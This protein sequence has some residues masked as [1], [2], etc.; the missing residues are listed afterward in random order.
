MFMFGS[1]ASVWIA[2]SL[3]QILCE[4][5]HYKQQPWIKPDITIKRFFEA[6]RPPPLTLSGDFATNLFGK[7]DEKS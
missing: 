1:P 4:P 3:F 5:E 7:F 6:P 2:L